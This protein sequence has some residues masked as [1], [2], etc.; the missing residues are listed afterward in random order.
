M[1]PRRSKGQKKPAAGGGSIRIIAGECRGMKLEMP[2]PAITRPTSARARE[3]LFNILGNGSMLD[4]LRGGV[5][6]DLFAG[7]GAIGLEALSRGAPDALFVERDPQALAVTRANIEACRMVKR[8]RLVK[9]DGFNPPA[10]T[11]PAGIVFIDPPYEAGAVERSLTGASK[12]G[13]FG[14]ETLIILQLDPKTALTLDP[15]FTVTDDRRYGAA[16]FVFV[17]QE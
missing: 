1:P 9:G 16:R 8:A 10:R 6:V 13:Y 14:P 5:F 17:K 3:S 4:L 7:S 11:E 15:D 12:A 2:D